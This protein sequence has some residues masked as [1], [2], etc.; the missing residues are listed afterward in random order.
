MAVL[1]WEAQFLRF[2]LNADDFVSWEVLFFLICVIKLNALY[3]DLNEANFLLFLRNKWLQTD[4]LGA[5]CFMVFE[6]YF[7]Y[8]NIIT[9][10]LKKIV[11]IL[12]RFYWLSNL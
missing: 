7:N 8:T 1:F 12:F 2:W 5:D 11:K 3:I 9:P 10:Y 6:K 4:F